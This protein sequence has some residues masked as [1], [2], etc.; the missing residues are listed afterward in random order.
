MLKRD[1]I[2]KYIEEFGKVVSSLIRKILKDGSP[3][4]VQAT[5]AE[6]DHFLKEELSTD[7]KT[8]LEKD[9]EYLLGILVSEKTYHAA[10]AEYM[11][12][13]LQ[14]FAN[15]AEHSMGQEKKLLIRALFLLEHINNTEKTF[16]T[17]RQNKI[18]EIH[19]SLT[20]YES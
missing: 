13:L 16:S 2:E 10:R 20:K 9:P 4:N 14:A 1:L 6:A 12:D 3:E 11:A 7:L 15:S 5:S 19:K 18:T 17:I 8:I